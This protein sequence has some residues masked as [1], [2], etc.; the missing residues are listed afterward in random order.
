MCIR[1]FGHMHIRKRRWLRSF[2]RAAGDDR[3]RMFRAEVVNV[4]RRDAADF[5]ARL[6]ADPSFSNPLALRAMLTSFNLEQNASLRRDVVGCVLRG[7]GGG[8]GAAGGR[9]GRRRHHPHCGCRSTPVL[10]HTAIVDAHLQRW[11]AP[12]CVV[13]ACAHADAADAER[14]PCRAE[15]SALPTCCARASLRTR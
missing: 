10:A 7:G 8:G 3:A 1:L 4:W 2:K 14:A 9:G 13:A 12:T 15:W 6:V 11:V 5:N